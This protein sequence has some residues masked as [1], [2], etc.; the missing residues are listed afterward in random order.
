MIRK[1]ISLEKDDLKKI[2]SIVDKHEGNL[3]AAIREVINFADYAINNFGDLESVKKIDGSTDGVVFPK[4]ILVWLLIQ[5]EGCLPDF[6]T[7]DSITEQCEIEK[8]KDVSCNLSCMV[9]LCE[10]LSV[11]Y[12]IKFDNKAKYDK[13]PGHDN[14]QKDKNPHGIE[15]DLHGERLQTEFIAK[16]ISCILGTSCILGE[17]R[18]YI[19]SNVSK[20]ASF[21]SMRF[22]QGGSYED[23]RET[24][25]KYFGNRHVMTQ[26]IFDKPV[27][28]NNVITST[29][30]W[31]DIQK[32]KYPK[33]YDQKR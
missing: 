3:S 29:M 11:E 15:I 14:G 18:N 30:E 33:I 25:I 19:L 12:E 6:K 2:E 13:V 27:F 4:G 26:E 1:N 32:H 17:R 20:H 23:I 10:K 24:L 9:G 7:I 31:S 28:W 5:T 21:I 16:I 8:K 22:D